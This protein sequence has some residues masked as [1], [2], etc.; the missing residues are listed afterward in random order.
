MSLN[1]TTMAGG[2]TDATERAQKEDA[3]GGSQ[4]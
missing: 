2:T 4:S 3:E 1:R